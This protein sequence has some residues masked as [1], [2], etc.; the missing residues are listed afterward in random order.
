MTSNALLRRLRAS[1]T[2]AWRCVHRCAATRPGAPRTDAVVHARQQDTGQ[3][4]A[5][6]PANSL[7]AEVRGDVPELPY[8][9][10]RTAGAPIPRPGAAG[11]RAPGA[12]LGGAPACATTSPTAT[13]IKQARFTLIIFTP[14]GQPRPAQPA[15]PQR[16]PGQVRQTPKPLSDP[17]ADAKNEATARVLSGQRPEVPSVTL[18]ALGGLKSSEFFPSVVLCFICLATSAGAQHSLYGTPG[19]PAPRPVCDHAEPRR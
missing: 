2:F 6:R 1:G 19:T 17:D 14:A 4:T 3:A 8:R 11:S 9:A 16:T 5:P 13:S 7:A 10:E 15:P 18:S 12:P